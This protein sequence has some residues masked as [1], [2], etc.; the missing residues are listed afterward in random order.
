MR[1][2]GEAASV[3]ADSTLDVMSVLSVPKTSFR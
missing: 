2:T 3:A 1:E